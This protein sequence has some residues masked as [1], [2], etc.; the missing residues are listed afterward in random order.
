MF[1]W[2]LSEGRNGDLWYM[3]DSFQPWQEMRHVYKYSLTTPP[4]LVHWLPSPSNP[5]SPHKAPPIC[6][7]SVR[8]SKGVWHGATAR[9]DQGWKRRSGWRVANRCTGHSE[10]VP[11]R[12]MGCNRP[13]STGQHPVD[14][15][16]D[17]GFQQRDFFGGQVEQAVD[18]VV[19]LGFGLGDLG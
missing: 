13:C 10:A 5:L 9:M 8:A 3:I 6:K 19:D 1:G 7:R 15:G 2:G 12:Y 16:S 17:R 4:R 18:D 11:G 14:L